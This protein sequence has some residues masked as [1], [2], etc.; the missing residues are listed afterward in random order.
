MFLT[1]LLLLGLTVCVP[2]KVSSEYQDHKKEFVE[3]IEKTTVALIGINESGSITPYCSGVWVSEDKILTAQHCINKGGSLSIDESEI[4]ILFQDFK[5]QEKLA[6]LAT[7]T[8]SDSD[9]DLA[10]IKAANPPKDH[11]VA[12]VVK[13]EIWDG[14]KVAIVGHTSGLWWSYSEGV[15]SSTRID[16]GKFSKLLQISSP[17]WFGNSGGGAF[18]E[19]GN[20]VGV[21]SWI[22][23][24]SPMVT[25]FI[26]QDV[27]KEF[28]DKNLR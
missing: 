8:A 2:P 19:N 25:F 26:H 18:D 22:M 15:V 21:C 17:A 20:L 4:V 10:L 7:V 13:N 16:V 27:I 6:R 24:K 12:Q 23:V 14:Q 28:L 9:N 5:D 11:P 1:S 3:K